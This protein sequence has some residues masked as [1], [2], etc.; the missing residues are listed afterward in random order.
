M[1]HTGRANPPGWPA[2][3]AGRPVLQRTQGRGLHGVLRQCQV[4]QAQRPGQPAP[5]RG[6]AAWPAACAVRCGQPAPP[7]TEPRCVGSRS[8]A[9]PRDAGRCGPA[10]RRPASS[11]GLDG[12][13]AARPR[14]VLRP[15]RR[16]HP[17]GDGPDLRHDPGRPGCRGDQGRTAGRRQHAPPA[18]LGRRLLRAVQPQQAQPGGEREGPTRPEIVLRLVADADV[19]SENFKAGTMDKLGLGSR[20]CSTLNPRLIQVSH[21]GFL[22]GPYENRTALDEVVQMMGGL[23]Y[24][25][26]PRAARCA[27]APASTTSWAACSAPS[28]CWRRCSSATAHRHRPRPGGAKRA[29]REQRAAGG[30]AHDAVRGD[31]PGRRRRCPAASAPGPCTTCSPCRAASRSSWPR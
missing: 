28:A 8:T 19:F 7:V 26:G 21:K 25:T 22:P 2:G 20:R 5:P 24:M 9:C 3:R 12:E 1:R 17:H 6:A 13:V 27:P 30:A 29:V 14:R 15:R 31:R 16:I 10:P 11:G 18:G 23:A 4:R